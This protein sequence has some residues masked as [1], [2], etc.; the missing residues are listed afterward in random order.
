MGK[1]KNNFSRQTRGNTYKKR[2]GGG[3]PVDE[4]AATRF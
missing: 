3:G 4:S 1:K 2:G